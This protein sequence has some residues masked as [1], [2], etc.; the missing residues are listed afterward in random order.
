MRYFNSIWT[1][2]K[3]KQEALV[4][5][6]S[7]ASK[8][9]Q[10]HNWC[11][12]RLATLLPTSDVVYEYA[13]GQTEGDDWGN[14]RFSPSGSSVLSVCTEQRS[15][16]VDKHRKSPCAACVRLYLQSNNCGASPQSASPPV[17][18]V[19]VSRGK[20]E[21]QRRETDKRSSSDCALKYPEVLVV[22]Q[23]DSLFGEAEVEAGGISDGGRGAGAGYSTGGDAAMP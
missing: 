11:E 18:A 14:A 1:E 8:L 3:I 22:V 7:A 13:C 4:D 20:D 12:G 19:N 17:V 16:G 23:S 15:C 6:A 9:K 2:N 10:R 5:L 21:L